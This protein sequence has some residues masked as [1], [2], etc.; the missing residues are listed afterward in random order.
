MAFWRTA[1]PGAWAALAIA[2]VHFGA[3]LFIGERPL[4]GYFTLAWVG[5]II[6]FLL[7]PAIVWLAIT[8]FHAIR[9]KAE[10]L[11]GHVASQLRAEKTRFADAAL[12]LLAYALVNRSY[13][14]IKVAIPRLE[15]FWADPLFVEWDRALF[16]TDPWRLTHQFIGEAG[17]RA[18][19]SAYFAWITVVL[20]AYGVAA[21]A[22]DR[23]LQIQASLTYLLVWILLGNVMALW[24]SSAGP[25]FYDDFFGSDHYAPLMASLAQ[26]DLFANHLQGF[27]LE[28]KDDEAIGSGISAMPSVHCALTM[29]IVLLAHRVAGWKWALP[30]LAYH[31][32]ILVGSVHLGWHYAVDGLVSTTLVLPLWWAVGWLARKIEP[33]PD[34]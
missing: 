24:L 19:D 26:Q 4:T 16:G 31:I 13:R 18:I 29:L 10:S 11:V 2:V 14:A 3:A 22:R 34:A 17:T 5:E 6:A 15:E 25:A 21:F 28:W 27:L 1:S 9:A 20:I 8:V 30:A 33:E 23:Q 7:L 32:V 12:L